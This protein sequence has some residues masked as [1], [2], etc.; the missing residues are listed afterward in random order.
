MPDDTSDIRSYY[1]ENVD[2]ENERLERH[3][4]ERDLTRRYLQEY[5]PPGGRILE[6]GASTGA[7]THWLAQRG[8][9]LA[10]VDF[11]PAALARNQA[12]LQ[13]IAA[14]A[15]PAAAKALLERVTY[16]TADIR[17]LSALPAEEYDAVLIMGP[18]YHLIE[19]GDRQQAVS[20]ALSFLRPGGILAATFITRLGILGDLMRNVPQ[21]IELVE[22]MRSVIDLGFDPP[23]WPRGGFRGYFAHAAEIDPFFTSLGLQ[24]LALAALEPA[25]SADDEAYNRLE[26][27]QRALWLELL[28]EI[29]RQPSLLDSSRHLIYLGRKAD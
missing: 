22:E 9:S 20:Q 24:T 28:V 2:Q 7:Y 18:L 26:G 11:S 21:W 29:S 23:D 10:A 4:L 5:L 19:R 27:R 1:D 3:Q 13:A 12:Q 17:D 15:D 14:Q 25:I 8:H 6:L 16:A